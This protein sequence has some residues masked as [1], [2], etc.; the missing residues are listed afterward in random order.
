MFLGAAIGGN[1]DHSGLPGRGVAPR[2]LS[3]LSRPIVLADSSGEDSSASWGLPRGGG[4]GWF[5]NTRAVRR[6]SLG[7][8]DTPEGCSRAPLQPRRWAGARSRASR[9]LG[10][11][12]GPWPRTGIAWRRAWRDVA[13]EGR[14]V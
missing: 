12:A 3:V 2:G 10:R 5:D 7:H 1:L 6:R 9:D 14:P 13:S 8:V 4:E 11:A